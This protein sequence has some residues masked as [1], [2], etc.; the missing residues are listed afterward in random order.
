MNILDF[1]KSSLGNF[2]KSSASGFSSRKISF[3]NQDKSNWDLDS[4]IFRSFNV[5]RQDTFME[6][7]ET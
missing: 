1:R 7:D 5:P 6:M 3:K 2:R 4:R